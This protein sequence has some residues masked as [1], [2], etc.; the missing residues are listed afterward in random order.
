[1][2][3]QPPSYSSWADIVSRLVAFEDITTQ[4]GRPY[5]GILADDDSRWLLRV[6][7]NGVSSYPVA[8]INEG[9][10]VRTVGIDVAD[11]ATIEAVCSS[12]NSGITP[13]EDSV[14]EP[15]AGMAKPYLLRLTSACAWDGEAGSASLVVEDGQE[16]VIF[17]SA[18]SPSTVFS[19]E[20]VV[21]VS[22]IA[23]ARFV[24]M[25]LPS[26][27]L[28]ATCNIDA[29]K[30]AGMAETEF[31]YRASFV[32][33]GNTEVHN[34]RNNTTFDYNWGSVNG[35]APWY[36]GQPYGSTS[37]AALN[38]DI[39]IANDAAR[40][41]CGDPWR[42]PKASEFKELFDNVDYLNA[43]GTIKP[44]GATD[45]R[46]TLNGIVGL[47]IQS[48]INGNRLFF[49]CTGYGNGTS[50]SGR[51]IDGL[52]W[53]AT[54]YSARNARVLGSSASSVNP[55][56]NFYRYN[57]IPVRPVREASRRRRKES[58]DGSEKRLELSKNESGQRQEVSEN[59]PKRRK[60]V[61]KNES[62]QRQDK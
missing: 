18:T 37:G 42:M 5:I 59:K 20:A 10:K 46:I 22:E 61:S 52:Y 29:S 38:S 57:G 58:E 44:A 21:S 31:T 23:Y 7:S 51:G 6:I 45:K 27:L 56:Y 24:D 49:P 40:V 36:E 3:P 39:T 33:W 13:F 47:W 1:M 28:W 35:N 43:D 41:I 55:Q 30:P 16:N 11:A 15:P 2:G 34:P 14:T 53:S 50:W 9:V 19:E 26:G 32:S 25:G 62:G 4:D 12:Y 17:N 60:K 8:S 54:Y 48:K